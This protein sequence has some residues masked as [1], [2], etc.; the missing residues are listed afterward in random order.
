MNK[1]EK[2]QSFVWMSNFDRSSED[3]DSSMTQKE[4]HNWRPLVEESIKLSRFPI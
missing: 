3:N 2:F 4:M 1:I